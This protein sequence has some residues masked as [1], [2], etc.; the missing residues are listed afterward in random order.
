[1]ELSGRRRDTSADRTLLLEAVESAYLAGEIH[2]ARRIAET[3]RGDSTDTVTRARFSG[4]IGHCDVLLG[5]LDSAQA[6][7]QQADSLLASGTAV[8]RADVL[9]GLAYVHLLHADLVTAERVAEAAVERALAEADPRSASRGRRVLAFC[10][11]D[12]RGDL[13]VAYRLLNLAVANAREARSTPDRWAAESSL[14]AVSMVSSTARQVVDRARAVYDEVARVGLDHPLGVVAA[15]NATVAVYYAGWWVEALEMLDAA[16]ASQ[17]QGEVDVALHLF[18]AQVL[19]RRGHFEEARAALTVATQHVAAEPG[20][21]LSEM[22]A[23][24]QAVVAADLGQTEA[25][26][27]HAL[28]AWRLAAATDERYAIEATGQCLLRAEGDAVDRKCEADPAARSAASDAYR[29]LQDLAARF[30]GIHFTHGE[31]LAAA[32]MSRI[33]GRSDPEAWRAA[34]TAARSIEQPEDVAYSLFRLAEAELAAGDRRSAAPH[35]A[36]AAAECRQLGAAVLVRDIESLA[37]RSRLNVDAKRSAPETTD[38]FGLTPRERDVLG[39]LGD[40]LSNRQIGR[41]LFISERTAAVHVGNILTKLDVPSRT[42][43][44]AVAAQRYERR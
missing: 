1:V 42:R 29:R 21:R 39:L 11:L 41:R 14:L 17:P 13:E 20:E 27:T 26:R 10:A 35:L 32:E 5:D 9:A 4:W 6:A 18:R 40:G 30:G 43:A 2:A 12:L 34:V 15:H 23:Y 33:N 24:T 44:A 16:I 3:G 36:S 38:P 37:R 8:G 19:S 25:A 7:F 31:A 28:L 22:I